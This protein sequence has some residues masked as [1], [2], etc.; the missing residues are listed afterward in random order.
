MRIVNAAYR[1]HRVPILQQVKTAFGEM[2]ERHAVFLILEDGEGHQGIGESWVNFPPWAAWERAAMFEKVLIPWFKG[3]Q[4]DD[5]AAVVSEIYLALLGP[6]QQSGTVGPLLQAI[7]AVE[8][9]LWD[10]AAQCK[11]I[12]LAQLLFEAPKDRVKVYASGIGSSIP[13]EFIDEHMARGVTLFKLKLGF[14]NEEDRRNLRD[15]RK[16]LGNRTDIAVDVNRAWNLREA[17]NWLNILKDYDVRWLEEPLRI[18]EENRLE[19]LRDRSPIPIAGGEN[20]LMPP[21]CN[22]NCIVET[23]LD[24]L[25]PDLTKYSPLHVA[26]ELLDV[27]KAK[28]KR[29]IPHFLGSAPGQAASLH[30]AAG[31]EDGM[32]EWDLNQNALRTA[33]FEE[34][35]QIQDGVI[36][37]PN[38]AG[39]GWHLKDGIDD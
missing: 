8:L 11:A 26:L 36:E 21:G 23:S 30:F 13:W 25:Q 29:V 27:S 18:E 16:H 6:A 17:L 34:P 3:R 15:L 1:H 19:A 38:R 28:G 9:A 4:V 32:V 39:L 10:L 5:I 22:L 24:I 35:F 7:C 37:I 20:V 2:N 33:L 12:P 14:G 31:C